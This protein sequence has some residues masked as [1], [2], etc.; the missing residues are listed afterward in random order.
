MPFVRVNGIDLA[1]EE[2][3]DD[4][5]A[6]LLTHGSW[7]DRRG[8]AA[9]VPGLA[10]SCR[11][12]TWD[13]RGHGQSGDLAGQGTR[14]QDSDD[15][16]GLIEALGIAPAHLVGNSFGGSITLGLAARRPELIRS[17]AVHEPP[18]FD[19]LIGAGEA[20]LN[21]A[22]ERIRLVTEQLAA[23]EFEAGAALF[24]DTVVGEP[25]SWERFTSDA[26]TMMVRHAPTFL[27]ENRDPAVFAL[28]LEGVSRFGHPA[29]LSHG[30]AS[31]GYFASAVKR[32][33]FALSN[34]Q[35]HVFAGAGHVPHR[36]HPVDFVDILTA[37]VLARP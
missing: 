30:D 2:H 3:G 9:V 21:L 20:G 17:L 14:E 23:G 19:V 16:A 25:G 8:W 6:L 7:G 29:L 33:A 10:R 13:R 11:V 4:G 18:V 34:A 37:F 1:F 28:D 24:A 12:V 31:P 36:S 15:L 5:P 22:R 35:V 26:Q 27:E 32:V